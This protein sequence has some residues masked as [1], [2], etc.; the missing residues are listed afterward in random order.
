MSYQKDRDE[1]IGVMIEEMEAIGR[2]LP[3]E[4]RKGDGVG[5]ARLILRNA[6]TIQSCETQV[7]SSEA[8]DRDRVPCPAIKSG[9]N[10]DCAC[11][12]YQGNHCDTPRVQVSSLRA[13][14]RIEAACK[15]WG[16][17]PNFSGDPRGCCVN[18]ILPSGRYNSWGGAEDG[19]CVPVR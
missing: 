7:C 2:T 17:K 6:S 14:Q 4:D 18:L 8:A 1:F 15:P 10:A 3:P 5:L 13:R 19:F 16:I 9:D 12:R 11:D